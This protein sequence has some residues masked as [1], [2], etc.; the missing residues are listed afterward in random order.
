MF[1][2]SNFSQNFTKFHKIWLKFQR[3]SFLKIP[4][5]IC[6][7]TGRLNPTYT[8]MWNELK[9]HFFNVIVLIRMNNSIRNLHIRIPAPS[10]PRP[11]CVPYSGS[12]RKKILFSIFIQQQSKYNKEGGIVD[13][14]RLKKN[15]ILIF[16]EVKRI[17][18]LTKYI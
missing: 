13:S 18:I 6:I 4:Y 9:Y 3:F 12:Q 17:S 16:L 5:S 15:V 11:C 1:S 7:A 10:L 2:V 14:L 8:Y